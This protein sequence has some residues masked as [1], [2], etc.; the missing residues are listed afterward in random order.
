MTQKLQSCFI[1]ASVVELSLE[2]DFLIASYQEANV[3]IAI[4]LQ[5]R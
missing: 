4:G 2:E 5:A 1:Y 3:D